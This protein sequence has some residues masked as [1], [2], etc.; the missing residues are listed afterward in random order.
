MPGTLDNLPRGFISIHW[1]IYVSKSP[2]ILG[3]LH[4]AWMRGIVQ[5]K[6]GG[7]WMVDLG[8]WA[9]VCPAKIFVVPPKNPSRL[10]C[11]GNASTKHRATNVTLQMFKPLALASTIPPRSLVAL[12]A[13]LIQDL[14]SIRQTTFVK[15][16]KLFSLFLCT[17]FPVLS[18]PQR[19]DWPVT[20]CSQEPGYVTHLAPPSIGRSLEESA[21]CSVGRRERTER[22]QPDGR[23]PHQQHETFTIRPGISGPI[24]RD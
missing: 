7:L 16:L 22:T 2:G 3:V 19:L 1:T 24:A 11:P 13:S 15:L 6:C 9:D 23:Y 21:I 5:Y 12:R 20:A 14:G 17:H 8:G 18:A 4:T 10:H